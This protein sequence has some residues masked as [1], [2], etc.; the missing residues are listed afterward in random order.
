M[1]RPADPSLPPR[2]LAAAYALWTA[3]GEGAVTIRDVA[4]KANTTT[5]SVYAHFADRD[6]I[7]RGVRAQAR[8]HFDAA[9]AKSTGVLDGCGRLLDFVEAYPRDYEL[10]FGYG[11]RDR[12]EED[13]LGAEFAGFEGHIRRAGVRSRDVR[14]TA[15]ALACILHGAAMFRLAHPRPGAWA[16]EFRKATLDACGALLAERTRAKR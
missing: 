1:P 12:A 8:R 14:P 4:R 6:A 3:G 2:I 13:V 5:P 9:M 15:L 10:L 7:V 11:Y 16:P